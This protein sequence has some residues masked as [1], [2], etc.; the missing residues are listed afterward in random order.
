ML[1]FAPPQLSSTPQLIPAHKHF[2]RV[3]SCNLHT[4]SLPPQ[5]PATPGSPSCNPCPQTSRDWRSPPPHT[6]SLL[7]GEIVALSLPTSPA[8][9]AVVPE[10]ALEQPPAVRHQTTALQHPHAPALRCPLHE[11]CIDRCTALCSYT[12]Q[13]KPSAHQSKPFISTTLPLNGV[14]LPPPRSVVCSTLGQALGA[15][16]P[17]TIIPC[18]QHSEKVLEHT[19]RE[20]R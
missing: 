8:L 2:T 12:H 20:P 4:L 13:H 10:H 19:T 1:V 17:G 18:V 7:C 3:L 15:H 11:P 5:R 6:R 9:P 16:P 14:C